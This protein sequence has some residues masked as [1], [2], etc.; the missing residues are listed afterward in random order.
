MTLNPRGNRVIRL[1]LFEWSQFFALLGWRLMNS[2]LFILHSKRWPFSKNSVQ[3]WIEECHH[4]FGLIVYLKWIVHRLVFWNSRKVA[5][6]FK[7]AI[8]FKNC[9]IFW[10][11]VYVNNCFVD[12]KY[13]PKDANKKVKISLYC[14]L[15]RI[16]HMPKKLNGI[17]EFSPSTLPWTPWTPCTSNVRI[18]IKK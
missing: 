2:K 15:I 18:S 6:F 5:K 12:S 7:P 3:L 13:V 9:Y 17:T 14:F 11:D 4:F 8:L 1:L 16:A 10:N